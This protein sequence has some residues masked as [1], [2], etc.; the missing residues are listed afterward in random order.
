M[1]ISTAQVFIRPFLHHG[2]DHLAT[3]VSQ[4]HDQCGN[5]S[6][7][8]TVNGTFWGGPTVELSCSCQ[9]GFIPLDPGLPSIDN[10]CICTCPFNIPSQY[11]LSRTSFFQVQPGLTFLMDC[12][13]TALRVHSQKSRMPLQ[14]MCALNVLLEHFQVPSVLSLLRIVF[15]A[16]LGRFRRY[17]GPHRGR[18]A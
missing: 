2:S 8:T 12:A 16:G 7:C 1:R 14:L 10:P 3:P 6:I 5:H 15:N 13:F 4:C 9:E 17:M 11:Q 18:A